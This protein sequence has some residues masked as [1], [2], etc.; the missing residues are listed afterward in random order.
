M[1]LSIFKRG[2]MH[3]CAPLNA[4]LHFT[5]IDFVLARIWDQSSGSTMQNS[6]RRK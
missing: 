4:N 2:E 3:H 6:Q 5:R 1:H